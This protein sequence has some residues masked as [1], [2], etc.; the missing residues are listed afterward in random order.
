MLQVMELGYSRVTLLSLLVCILC[1][2]GMLPLLSPLSWTL[3]FLE[4]SRFWCGICINGW[5]AVFDQAEQFKGK[6]D[7]AAYFVVNFAWTAVLSKLNNLKHQTSGTYTPSHS[8][9]LWDWGGGE[10]NSVRKLHRVWWADRFRAGN[11][12]LGPIWT[13]DGLIHCTVYFH[14]QQ[15]MNRL[16]PNLIHFCQE[17][18]KSF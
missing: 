5:I 3:T 8:V 10:V 15:I 1:E 17:N 13:I 12:E 18:R 16:V 11:S 4:W 6:N 14:F 2:E 9:L 7:C